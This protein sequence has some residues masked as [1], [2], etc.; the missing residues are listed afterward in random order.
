MLLTVEDFCS[1]VQT[2][3]PALVDELQ[4]RTQRY[5]NAEAD[6]H[7]RAERLHIEVLAYFAYMSIGA[8]GLAVVANCITGEA[9]ANANKGLR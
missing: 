9:G 5:G 2:R 7:S 6:A 4:D 1:R 3:L 8:V